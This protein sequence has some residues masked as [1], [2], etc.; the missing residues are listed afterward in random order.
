MLLVILGHRLFYNLPPPSTHGL[1]IYR[2]RTLRTSDAYQCC[3]GHLNRDAISL[4]ALLMQHFDQRS[5]T[6]AC[7]PTSTN[8]GLTNDRASLLKRRHVLFSTFHSCQGGIDSS[9]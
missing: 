9:G 5:I 3:N 8:G 6:C 1:C 7:E 2:T 4:A